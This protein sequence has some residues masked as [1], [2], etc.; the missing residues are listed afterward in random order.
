MEAH[1]G[2]KMKGKID[3]PDEII[4]NC[5]KGQIKLL[6]GFPGYKKLN[7]EKFK[8]SINPNQWAIS[9][10]GEPTIYPKL[11][12]LIKKLKE[13]KCTVFVV[14]NGMFPNKLKSIE[15]PTQLYLSV[16]AP[17]KGLFKK[18]DRPTQKGAWEKLNKSLAILK[19][20]KKTTRTVIRITLLKDYNDTDLEGY[21]KLINQ[22]DPNFVEVKGYMFVGSSR[23]RL[24]LENMPRHDEVKEFSK[25]LAKKLGWKIINESEPSRVCLL[26]KENIDTNIPQ[27]CH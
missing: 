27:Q 26:A 1:T 16:D 7:K 23:L 21:V 15:P 25:S 17:N 24:S 11:N 20:L 6:N 19:E 18:I 9:L 14:S 22:A 3:D 12:Q 8:E 5:I 10:T 2:I 4:E 13:R